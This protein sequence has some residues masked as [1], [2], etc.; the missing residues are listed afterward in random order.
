[1]LS[2][3]CVTGLIS[4][5]S[6]CI[7]C[8]CQAHN[9]TETLNPFFGQDKIDEVMDR[10][11]NATR[12]KEAEFEKGKEK[13]SFCDSCKFRCTFIQKSRSVC[14]AVFASSLIFP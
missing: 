14:V 7:L 13:V 1:M 8:L 10:K 9:K 3:W 12:F 2:N 4:Y 11:E 6:N 5:D